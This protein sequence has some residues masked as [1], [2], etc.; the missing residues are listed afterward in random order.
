MT[1]LPVQQVNITPFFDLEKFM[2]LSGQKRIQTDKA[3]EL[4]K[5]WHEIFAYLQAYKLGENQEGYL[6]IYLHQDFEKRLDNITAINPEQGQELQTMAQALL[7]ASLFEAEPEAAHS[8]CA[9]VPKP[10]KALK[11]SLQK[12]DLEFDESGALNVRFGLLT[13]IPFAGDCEQCYI[14]SS[15]A[16]RILQ[17]G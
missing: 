12:L 3:R 6:L 17:Q 9:P 4:E 5:I 8:D 1:S 2:L 7:M 13:G 15:C 14:S 11:S 10:D 16:K